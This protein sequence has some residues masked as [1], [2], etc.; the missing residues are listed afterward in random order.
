MTTTIK[1]ISTLGNR[2][3]NC[4]K[5]CPGICNKPRQGIIL[6]YLYLEERQGQDKNYGYILVGINPGAGKRNNDERNCYKRKYD[7][8]KK[9]IKYSDVFNNLEKSN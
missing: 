1:K 5:N 3:V 7:K 2:L 8:N 4:N 6:R 9:R